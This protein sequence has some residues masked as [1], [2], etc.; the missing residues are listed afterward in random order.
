MIEGFFYVRIYR[1]RLQ[2]H[3]PIWW[4]SLKNAPLRKAE[5]AVR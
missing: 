3:Q 4:L 5:A 2:S 1:V